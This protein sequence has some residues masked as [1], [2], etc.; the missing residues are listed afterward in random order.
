MDKKNIINDETKVNVSEDGNIIT[1]TNVGDD[2][3]T[4][5]NT[6]YQRNKEE[7]EEPEEDSSNK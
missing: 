6:F 2:G 5:I 3:S 4:Y 1:F 7:I